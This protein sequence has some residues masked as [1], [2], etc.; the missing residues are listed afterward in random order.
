M[1]TIIG[2]IWGI[3]RNYADH[4]KEMGYATPAAKPARP[5]VFMKSAATVVPAG[6]TIHLPAWSKDVH[7][8][9][10]IAI[11]LDHR[12]NPDA[13]AI[14]LDLT[15]RDWQ[16]ELKAQG[17]PWTLAKSFPDSCPLGPW[18]PLA[19]AEDAQSLRF[20]LD[21]NGQRRQTGDA[22]QMIFTV[23]EIVPYLA[24]H[25]PL[26]PGDVILTGTPAGVAR[27]APGDH[28]S[29]GFSGGVGAG[30][31]AEWTCAPS[32]KSGAKSGGA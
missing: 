18:N 25:F 32:T 1:P 17:Q 14:A 12:L 9:V 11:R 31:G 27:L 26:S 23:G 29:A 19:R 6:G 24:A 3:G 15:A 13:Y 22:S 2:T 16:A 21:V 7:H 10:E 5:T 8:E 30:T 20:W 28:A 4:A